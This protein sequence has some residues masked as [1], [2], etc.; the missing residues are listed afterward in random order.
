MVESGG[1][2]VMA[3]IIQPVTEQGIALAARAWDE[4]VRQRALRLDGSLKAYER[5]RQIE[6]NSFALSEPDPVDKMSPLF[7]QLKWLGQAGFKDID[8]YWVKAGHAIF[9]V[10]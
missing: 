6:W 10:R 1:V 9:G 5:F 4:A 2:F 8:V 3:D 7:D